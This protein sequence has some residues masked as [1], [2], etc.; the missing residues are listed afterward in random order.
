MIDVDLNGVVTPLQWTDLFGRD[1]ATDV[2][3][4][5]GK[6]RFLLEL[7]AS[8]PER[9]FLAVERAGKYHA[10]CCQRAAKRG[11]ANVRLIH[12]SA[13]D[14]VF[15]LLAPSSV[16]NVFVLFPDPWP[17]KRHHKRRFITPDNVAGVAAALKPAGRLLVKSDHPDY[18]EIIKEVLEASP[19]L[20]AIDPAQA[21]KGLPITGFE[22]KY[23][24]Q[25]R[26]IHSFAYRK[27]DG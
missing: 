10:L 4:G 13:E 27:A 6:G 7:A 19:A 16:E 15:R 12:T 14:L 23:M 17:K 8:N 9:N 18:A 26:Q 20:R 24:D 3:I 25:G 2:E 5:S 1:V 22:H 21:F 11:L